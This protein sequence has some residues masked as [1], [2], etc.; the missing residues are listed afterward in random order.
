MKIT[1]VDFNGGFVRRILQRVNYEVLRNAASEIGKSDDLP[2][3]IPQNITDDDLLKKIHHVLLEIDVING[4]LI[5]PESGRKFTITN[6]IPNMF[7]HECESEMQVDE[8]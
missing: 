3:E 4:E 7:E 6:G 1:P 8:T 2:V 5:C